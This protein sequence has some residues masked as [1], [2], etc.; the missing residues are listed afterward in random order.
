M[1]WFYR[2]VPTQRDR[3]Q[4]KESTVSPKQC[5]NEMRILIERRSFSGVRCLIFW[6]WFHLT[7]DNLL[8][9][10]WNTSLRSSQYYYAKQKMNAKPLSETIM[11]ISGKKTKANKRVY[12]ILLQTMQKWDD[13]TNSSRIHGNTNSNLAKWLTQ[14]NPN[15]K[16]I[17]SSDNDL[18]KFEHMKNEHS[19]CQRE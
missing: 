12:S 7:P 19:S 16:Q 11:Q 13:F 1:A 14:K 2:F 5:K 9:F 8:V 15:W 6:Y 17:A 3:K 10:I 4:T 18:N